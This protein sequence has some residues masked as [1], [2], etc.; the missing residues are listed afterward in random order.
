MAHQN[1]VT[2][3]SEIIAHQGRGLLMGNRG[4][5]HDAGGRLGK[6]RWTSDLWI[7]CALSF[8]GWHRPIMAPH[9]YTEL[10]FLDE[11]VAFAAGHRP[12]ATCRRSDYNRF[13]AA[14]AAAGLGQQAMA[15]EIDA[16]LHRARLTDPPRRQRLYQAPLA[17]LPDGSFITLDAQD[18]LV[19][20]RALHPYAP[21]GYGA[22]RPRPPAAQV[23]VLTPAPLITVLQAGYQ[24][25]IH[26]SAA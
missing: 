22:T 13:R 15:A 24:P 4:I 3:R 16:C 6:R 10:F 12:C 17:T 23:T 20:G 5:L 19:K 25:L 9:T 8:K 1:R 7:A 14:W 18:Y 2:P 11:A 26:P 21:D